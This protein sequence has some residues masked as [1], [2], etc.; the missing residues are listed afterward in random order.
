MRFRAVFYL[1]LT[2]SFL[3]VDFSAGQTTAQSTILSQFNP[4]KG[5]KRISYKNHTFA[6]WI[7]NILLKPLNSDVL[8]FRGNVFKSKDDT[9]VAAVIEW[10][11]K[12]RR[13]DQCMD[14]LVKFYSEYLWEKDEPENLSLP[15]PGKQSLKWSDWQQGYRP[16]FRGTHFDLIKSEKYN[17]S[18]YNYNKYL[19]LVF[20]ESH[21]QQFYIAYPVIE[22]QNV[23]VGDFI[24]KKG[25][26]GHAIMIVDL[27]KDNRGNLIALIGQGDT[28]A[29][30][31]YLLN[32]NKDDPWIPLDFSK[33][34]IP[35]PIN[36]KMTWDGLRRFE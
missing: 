9:T 31:F 32:Y 36:K 4:P 2:I 5:Y 13:L 16:K 23:Q 22:R 8:D 18:K 1:I 28:P 14:I 29:C 6:D 19:N 26:K 7:R 12:G 20:A 24:V 15:L 33:E 10:K 30:E 17:S 25:V 35:L 3:L 27:A 11:I 34:I 21:T